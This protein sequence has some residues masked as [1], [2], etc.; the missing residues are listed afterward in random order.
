MKSRNEQMPVGI[1]V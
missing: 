1:N